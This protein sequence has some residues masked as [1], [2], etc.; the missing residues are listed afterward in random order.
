MYTKS[1][2]LI[3]I[4]LVLYCSELRIENVKTGAQ[5]RPVE[6]VVIVDAGELPL[7]LEVDEDGNQVPVRVEL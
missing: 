2:K 3:R 1:V 7:E 5:D 6:D 4:F